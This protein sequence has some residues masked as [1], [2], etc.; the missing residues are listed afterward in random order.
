MRIKDDRKLKNI[1]G[2]VTAD[3]SGVS[4]LQEE[5]SKSEEKYRTILEQ[6]D[7]AYYEID[8]RGNLTYLNDATARMYG[9][10][11]HEMHGMSYKVFTPK[12]QWAATVRDYAA[13]FSTGIPY[14]RRSGISLKIDG[15]II[16]REDSI[17]PIRNERGVITGLRGI[18][19]DV[20]ERKRAED[21]LLEEKRFSEAVIDSLP[22]IF[23]IIDKD[24]AFVRYNKNSMDVMGY[25]TEEAKNLRAMDIIAEEDRQA[26]AL[27]LSEIF[28]VGAG[29]AEV[30]IVTKAGKKIPYHISAKRVSFGGNPY[31]LGTGIDITE[32][33]AAERARDEI[34]KNYR[35]LAENTSDVV[36]IID[37]LTLKTT[38]IS[39]SSSRASGFTMEELKNLPLEKQMTPESAKKMIDLF[40]TAYEDERAGLGTPERHYDVELE[41]FRK[42]G[43]TNW[44]ENRFQFIRD[45]QG[46]ATSM[47]MQGRDI[48]DRKRGRTGQGRERKELPSTGGEYH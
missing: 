21:A 8:A 5:L 40:L 33:L 15:K 6:M 11:R 12:D 19:R 2:S 28:D 25:S 27:K 1:L 29:E 9:C 16:Y 35:L 18:A 23:Y 38:W 41:V 26:I 32:R 42:D 17:F 22:G 13:V 39:A 7:E 30:S 47:L 10:S 44:T 43:S 20:T 14:R 24:G 4:Q 37:M 34:E 46:K 48:T 31:L 36:S 3:I 45:E